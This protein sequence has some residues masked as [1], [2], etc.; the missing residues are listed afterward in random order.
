MA[1]ISPTR[2]RR[3]QALKITTETYNTVYERDNG[4]CVLCAILGIHPKIT[5]NPILE[6]H[7]YISRGR[8]GMGIEENLL[9]LCKYHHIEETLYRKE[10]QKYLQ[11]K[12]IEWNED[13]LT[14]K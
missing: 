7:H 14:F 10:I 1:K 4:G 3:Q 9:L 13:K 6:L 12:Y 5:S 8:S 2:R 11:S